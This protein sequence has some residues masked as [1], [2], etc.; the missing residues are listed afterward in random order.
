MTDVGDLV[1]VYVEGV[2]VFFARVEDIAPDVKPQWYQVRMLVLQVPLV[3]ITWILRG[4]YIDGEEFSMGGKP[5]RLEKVVA[6][7]EEDA[8]V[9][10][11]EDSESH[12]ESEEERKG[13]LNIVPAREKDKVVSLVDRLKK[14]SE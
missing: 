12:G 2:P 7:Q 9:E 3:V 8:S 5:V 11:E 4:S 14:N 1:L 10:F 13:P 6:P